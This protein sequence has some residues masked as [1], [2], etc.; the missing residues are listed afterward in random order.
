MAFTTRFAKPHSHDAA[1]GKKI[2]ADADLTM[3][4]ILGLAWNKIQIK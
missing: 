4:P 1:P 2:K 3:S